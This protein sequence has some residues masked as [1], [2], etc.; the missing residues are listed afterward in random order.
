MHADSYDPATLREFIV[1]HFDTQE[2]QTLCQD[3]S[4]DFDLLHGEGKTGEAG[5]L[6]AYM[7]RNARLDDLIAALE[8]KRKIEW[9]SQELVKSLCN[10][11]RDPICQLFL[12]FLA[13][14]VAIIELSPLSRPVPVVIETPTSTLTPAATATPTATNTLTTTPTPTK[15]IV[16]WVVNEFL[17]TFPT[18]K[19]RPTIMVKPGT[20]ITVTVEEIV[21]IKVILPAIC[22][23][24]QKDLAF[25]WNT[26]KGVTRERIGDP[27]FLYV[28]PSEP[29]PDCICVVVKKGGVWLDRECMFVEVQ[30]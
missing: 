24:Q 18:T 7:E 13:L 4:V 11:L 2:L 6:V 30:E 19:D 5:E 28:A 9:R 14:L 25:T 26:C 10:I 22:E 27:E 12:G 20:T 17:V 15:G 16:E 29:G 23:E 8:E 3:L 21:Q 1:K